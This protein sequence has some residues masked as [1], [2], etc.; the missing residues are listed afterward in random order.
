MHYPRGVG[1]NADDS[2]YL[3]SLQ[4]SLGLPDF[5]LPCESYDKGMHV[6]WRTGDRFRMYF[7]RRQLG[8]RVG[9]NLTSLRS[10]CYSP[11]FN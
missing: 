6:E 9:D 7:G 3:L 4:L 11:C 5:L 2:F 1:C 10:T 8:A